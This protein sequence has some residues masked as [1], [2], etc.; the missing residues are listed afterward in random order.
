MKTV[1][2]TDKTLVKSFQYSDINQD[3]TAYAEVR[4]DGRLYHKFGI[5]QATTCVGNVFKVGPNK[6]VMYVGVARQ[7]PGDSR[8]DKKLAIEVANTKSYVDPSIVMEVNSEFDKVDFKL[9]MSRYVDVDSLRSDFIK[10]RE[11]LLKQYTR[12]DGTIDE[13]FYEF[14]RGPK[15]NKCL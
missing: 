8:I 3:R 5:I 15:N 13:K 9:I 2:F 4:I 11:E 7:N 1:K 12:E 14:N 6:Y 10:T